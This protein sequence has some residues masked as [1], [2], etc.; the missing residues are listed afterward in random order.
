MIENTNLFIIFA[1]IHFIHHSSSQ[2]KRI[3]I[4]NYY[5]LVFKCSNKIIQKN[6]ESNLLYE[7]GLCK[8][9]CICGQNGISSL[10]LRLRVNLQFVCV[11]YCIYYLL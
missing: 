5:L 7:R 2:L 11:Y 8:A 4:V 3:V 9:V 6:Q 1:F 10:Y